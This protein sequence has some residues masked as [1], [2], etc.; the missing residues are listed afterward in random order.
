MLLCA[1][2]RKHRAYPSRTRPGNWLVPLLL[3]AAP[4]GAQYIDGGP[5]R[6]PTFDT[7]GHP[8]YGDPRPGLT[9]MMRHYR[10]HKRGPQ[11]FCVVG[12]RY[13]DDHRNAYIVWREGRRQILWEGV[14]DPLSRVDAIRLSRRNLNMDTDVVP[15][16]TFNS[17]TYLIFRH[18]Q[19]D[20][21]G[22]CARGG[23]RYVL[24]YP[25]R[26]AGKAWD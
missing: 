8:D 10:T 2:E 14:S 22:D 20:I 4:A 25:K 12:Y 19:R 23:R 15:N 6:A 26:V 24:A 3:L 9:A 17:S 18:E 16:G 7:A 13:P 11:H 21:E 1:G 5:A